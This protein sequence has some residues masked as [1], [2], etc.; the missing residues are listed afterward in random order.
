[1]A[2]TEEKIPRHDTG[3][4]TRQKTKGG[5]ATLMERLAMYS[6]AN[7]APTRSVVPQL[8]PRDRNRLV[9]ESDA[10]VTESTENVELFE[11][12]KGIARSQEE[13]KDAIESHKRTMTEEIRKLHEAQQ[14]LSDQLN[15]QIKKVEDDMHRYVDSKVEDVTQVIDGLQERIRVLEGKQTTEFDPQVTLIMTKVP[16]PNDGNDETVA[17]RIIHQTLKLPDIQI[18]RT[19]RL[20]QRNLQNA[21]RPPPPLLKVELQSLQDKIRVLQAKRGLAGTNFQNVWIRSSM[22]H[23]ERVMDFNSRALLKLMGNQAQGMTVNSSG[24]IV[25]KT[26]LNN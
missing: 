20:P 14:K 23:S 22:Y 1:M 9:F 4:T 2:E 8:S 15:D 17:K 6:P 18:V 21:T 25:A 12:I 3:V 26:Q 10:K 24:R 11:M 16:P 7:A 19:M 5:H 13:I